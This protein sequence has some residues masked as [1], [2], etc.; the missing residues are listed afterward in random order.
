MTVPIACQGEATRAIWN[1]H[2]CIPVLIDS[3]NVSDES[4]TKNAFKM[5]KKQVDDQFDQIRTAF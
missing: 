4:S 1:N 5:F 3:M 2:D